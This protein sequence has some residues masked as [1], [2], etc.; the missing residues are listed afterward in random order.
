MRR[1]DVGNENEILHRNVQHIADG[2]HELV[3]P[4]PV[5]K[6][7]ESPAPRI[8]HSNMHGRV[9][10]RARCAWFGFDDACRKCFANCLRS[11]YIYCWTLKF[12]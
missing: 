5:L 6:S 9:C 1:H 2:L 7:L 8:I 4:L 12:I 3:F 10:V 11:V